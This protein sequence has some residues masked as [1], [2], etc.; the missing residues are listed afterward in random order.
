MTISKKLPK[1]HKKS[2][3]KFNLREAYQDLNLTHLLPWTVEYQP[4]PASATFHDYL[5]K[6][7]TYFNLDS[8][9]EGK[10]LIIDAIFLE[11]IQT[12][13]RLKIW[14]GARLEGDT[15]QGHA[16]YLIAEN[17]DYLEAPLLCV[18]EAKKDDFE[19][20]LAQCLVEMKKIAST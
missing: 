3:S 14:K 13:R 18:V 7:G 16:D 1:T 8:S 11:G 6:L 10:K 2:F 19:Q 17:K 5:A 12:F 9:E 4:I 15:A 20:G